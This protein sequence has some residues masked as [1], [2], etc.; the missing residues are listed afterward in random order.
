VLSIYGWE[1]YQHLARRY[2]DNEDYLTLEHCRVAEKRSRHDKRGLCDDA[3]MWNRTWPVV[4]AVQ[5]VLETCILRGAVAEI[6]WFAKLIVGLIGIGILVGVWEASSIWRRARTVSAGSLLP[7][8]TENVK[9][10]RF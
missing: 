6:L 5:Y 1:E 4:R 10:K 8:D 7:V 3:E 9:M 2:S